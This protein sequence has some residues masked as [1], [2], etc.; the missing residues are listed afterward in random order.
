MKKNRLAALLLVSLVAASLNAA[1]FTVT[2]TN[3]SGTGSLR[4]A[5]NGVATSSDSSNTIAFSIGTG[6][7]TIKPLYQFAYLTKPVIVDGTTQPGFNGKP[8]VEIDGS[9]LTGIGNVCIRLMGGNSVVKGLVINNYTCNR[10][11]LGSSAAIAV[12]S[13]NNVVAGN[14]IGTDLSGSVKKYNDEGIRVEDGASNNLIGGSSASVMT[15]NLISGNGRG[16]DLTGF[17]SGVSSGNLIKGNWVGSDAT[18]TAVIGN[19]YGVYVD[20]NDN[21]RIGGL[22]GTDANIFIGNVLGLVLNG[23]NNALVQGNRF[24]KSGVDTQSGGM[25][26]GYG[27]GNV[28]GGTAPGAPNSF[29][30]LVNSTAVYI[31]D[32]ANN[33][34]IGNSILNCGSGIHIAAVNTPGDSNNNVVG[35]TADGAGNVIHNTGSNPMGGAV[36]VYGATGCSLLRNSI[37]GSQGIGFDLNDDGV[38]LNDSGDGDS[39]ANNNQNFPVITAVSSID[40]TTS[41]GGTLNSAR[42]ATFRI[43]FFANA[44]CDPSGY[45]EGDTY[46]GYKN[47]TTD[48]S[49]NVAF[50]ATFSASLSASAVITAT[51]TDAAGNTSEFSACAPVYGNG[52]GQFALTSSSQTVSESVGSVAFTVSRNFGS[53]GTATV[54]YATTNGTATAGSDYTAVAGTLTFLDGETSKTITIP[55]IDDSVFEPSETFTLSLSNPTGGATLGPTATAIVTILDNDAKTALGADDVRVVEG[56][57]GTT[58]AVITLQAAQASSGSVSYSTVDGTAT[59]P[60][61]YAAASGTVTFNNETEKQIVINIHGDTDLEPDES[62]TVHLTTSDF[63]LARAD[64]RVT[65][66]NDDAGLS[67]TS[68]SI[69]KGESASL[70]A[71]IGSAATSPQTLSVAATDPCIKTPASV[72]IPTG[73]H[74][75]SITVSAITAPCSARV[76]VTFPPSAGGRTLSAN[77]RTYV[78]VNVSFDPTSPRV[79]VGHSVPVHVTI[80]PLDTAVVVGLQPMG[81]FATIPPTVTVDPTGGGHFDITGVAEGTM[82]INAVLPPQLGGAMFTLLVQ[83]DAAPVVANLLGASPSTGPVSGGTLVTL[84]G[85]NLTT[86]C[87]VS[88]GGAPAASVAFVGAASLVATTPARAAGTVMVKAA[89][90]NGVTT[91]A[92][93]FT[94]V[95]STPEVHTVAPSFGSSAG[96]TTVHINGRNFQPGCWAFFDGV[97][98]KNVNVIN[99]VEMTANTPAH[100]PNTVVVSIRC[101]GTS[102]GLLAD[103]FTYSPADDPAPVITSIRPL[104][105]SPG[106]KVTITGA[107]LRN[108]DT[109]AFDTTSAVIRSST[110]EEAVVLVPV[111]PAGKVSINVTD[112]AGR[113]STTGPIFDVLAPKPSVSRI[114][115]TSAPAGAELTIDGSGFCDPYKSAI[116]GATATT[117]AMSY[118]R[119]VVRIPKLPPGTHDVSVVDAAGAVAADGGKLNVTPSG[120]LINGAI[121]RCSTTDG[122]TNLT[123]TGSGFAPGAT[124]TIGGVIGLDVNVVDDGHITLTTPMLPPG[125]ATIV[126]TNPSGATATATNAVRVFSP[127]DPDGC[128]VTP[129]PRPVHH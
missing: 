76:D 97:A 62:F 114:S 45:G 94:F 72:T 7:V 124:V 33:S 25:A 98:A 32:S 21:P 84:S 24:G 73:Q 65:I 83:V 26:I 93:A 116:G 64:V 18:G 51:A 104:A 110:P 59:T 39:G 108:S 17:G 109:I 68:L 23:T 81:S 77:V 12:A 37:S 14:Y 91:L 6:P 20:Y 82:A 30:W 95:A 112:K 80:S 53:Q 101:S 96:G 105:A 125:F 27:G 92:N 85:T 61:D 113:V 102:D 128:G 50:T 118:N 89:C 35:G 36:R 9:N 46:L 28:I 79:Q 70:V 22:N 103:G 129:R 87:A 38:T 52:P 34:V 42:S 60:S 126:V 58:Q 41:I 54:N 13:S 16:V 123:L 15:R 67:P 127:F 121:A 90:G 49:G 100:A 56:N 10:N 75:A 43:E 8:I 57:S 117:V 55:I 2:N 44:A 29:L 111:M 74:S 86:D 120:I 48:G 47:V 88:F 115:P 119:T 4:E 31:Q 78:A 19:Y 40:G 1:V 11:G 5:M 63:S 107:R 99:D 122:G 66:A 106:D 71:D 69:A 3:D